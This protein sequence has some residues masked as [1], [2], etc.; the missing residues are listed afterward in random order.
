MQ[1]ALF[2]SWS[3]ILSGLLS[4]I[5]FG[6]LLRKGHLTRFS[7][8]V[9]QL[10]FKD[11][12]VMKVMMTALVFSST[13]FTLLDLDPSISET[14]I[15]AALAGGLL[16]GVGMAILG[17]CPGTAVGALA[18]GAKDVWFGILGMITGALVYAEA[19][20]YIQETIKPDE[21]LMKLSLT[22]YFSLSAWY[23][24]IP[25]IIG[26]TTAIAVVHFRQRQTAPTVF[27]KCS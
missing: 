12:T 3:E 20:G 22:D 13:C 25:I 6:F 15:R 7:T 19:Y 26:Y 4:G 14:T 18:D 11:F 5:V 9:N 17:Y 16:F 27:P 1:T 24:V 10:R 23:F 21:E 2:S 8:I